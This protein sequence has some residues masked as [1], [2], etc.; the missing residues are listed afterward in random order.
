MIV[1]L[2]TCQGL[3][4]A[5]L[6]IAR[7]A[8]FHNETFDLAFY[9]RIAWGLVRLDFWE[10]LVDAHVY[11]LHLSPVLVPLGA[12]GAATSTPVVLILAQALALALAA[13]P[14]AKIG[15]RHLGPAGALLAT[16]AWLFYPNPA[17]VAGYEVHPGSLAVLPIAWLAWSIDSG[18][19]RAFAL[20]ALGV[21]VCRE[22]LALVVLGAA[23]VHAWRHPSGR[24]AIAGVAAVTLAYALYFFLYLHPTH[25]PAQGS[26]QLHFGRFGS[27]LPEVAIHLLT[28]P[29]DLLAH[30]AAP[31]RLAYLPKVL[32][33]LALLPLLRP[34]WLIP[35]L[36]I[37]A[38]N[39]VSEWPTTTDLDVHYLTPGLPFLVAGALEGAAVAARRLPPFAVLVVV[40]LCVL[41]GH[42]VAGGTPLS[43]DFDSAAYAPDPLTRGRRALVALIPPDA[44]VQAP[45]ALLPHLAERRVLRRTTSPETNADFYVLDVAHR[46]RYAGDEDLIR[47]VEEPPVRDWMARD[48]HRLVFAGGDYYLLERGGDPRTGLGGRAIV[49]AASPDRGTALCDCLAVDGARFDGDVLE[50]RFVARGRCPSDLAIRIGTE[51]RP[52]R[53]DLLF[54]GWLSPV[55]LRAGDVAV[56]R[57][58]IGA[59]LRARIEARGLRVGA[60][61]Q[62]GARPEPDD[63]NS[64]PVP[65]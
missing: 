58:R 62:S 40:A 24:R 37:L 29:A 61:R 35:A 12:L 41:T 23:A 39:L 32:A 65:L 6:G 26:L 55:H 18:S 38:I 34:R 44:S 17:H 9:T 30:L 15:A 25:A 52:P 60:I 45:Y 10:P 47:T 42:A 5:T 63:P 51:D 3:L 59:A 49:G 28:H 1:A 7:Y 16:I 31:Q 13:F 27:S 14:L 54:G 57:H 56:S 53:V 46:R 8:T 11:G 22:D 48:D 2:I 36:P 43:L 19:A 33:P 64:V 4:F 50:L 20:G 21:L